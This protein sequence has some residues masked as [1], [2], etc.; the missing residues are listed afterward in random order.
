MKQKL[1][2]DPHDRWELKRHAEDVLFLKEHVLGLEV[3]LSWQTACLAPRMLR[4]RSPAPL[5]SAI[6]MFTCNTSTWEAE[7]RGSGVQGQT[8]VMT[9]QWVKLCKPDSLSL[10]LQDPQRNHLNPHKNI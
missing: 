1:C 7:A 2:K 8:G 9:V 4:T 6:V 10:G 5:K 3:G